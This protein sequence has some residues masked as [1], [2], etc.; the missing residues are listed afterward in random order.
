MTLRDVVKSELVGETVGQM[1]GIIVNRN[2]VHTRVRTLAS[3]Y[4]KRGDCL[5]LLPTV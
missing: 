3:C 5:C 4:G 1:K 2:P